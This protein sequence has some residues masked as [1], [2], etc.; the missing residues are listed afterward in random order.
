MRIFSHEAKE[1]KEA[2]EAPI[3]ERSDPS[4]RQPKQLPPPE[5]ETPKR[6]DGRVIVMTSSKAPTVAPTLDLLPKK[7]L[8]APIAAGHPPSPTSLPGT[9]PINQK[10]NKLKD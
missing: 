10:V 2:K 9:G 4:C 7:E 6:E 3:S 8:L 5:A 1:A